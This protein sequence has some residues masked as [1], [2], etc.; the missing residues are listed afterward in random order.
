MRDSAHV[1][2]A[3]AH[4]AKPWLSPFRSGPGALSHLPPC[5][6]AGDSQPRER[7]FV[8]PEQPFSMRQ[9]GALRVWAESRR[10]P[11]ACDIARSY[12]PREPRVTARRFGVPAVTL[13]YRGKE[14]PDSE[15]LPWLLSPDSCS[16]GRKGM[17]LSALLRRV[18]GEA[19]PQVQDTRNAHRA[20]ATD[21][22]RVVRVNEASIART[23]ERSRR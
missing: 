7:L 10:V 18:E 8:P 11:T 21:S 13:T 9:D 14:T 17:P 5:A 20:M 1:I 23:T 22:G 15:V 3:G 2:Q 12:C 6:H 19:L 4:G 16:F